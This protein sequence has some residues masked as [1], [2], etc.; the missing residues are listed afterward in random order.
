MIISQVIAGRRI[1]RPAVFNQELAEEL[2]SLH[3]EKDGYELVTARTMCAMDF[4]EGQGR[5]DGAF[6]DLAESEKTEYLNRLHDAGV[7]NIEMEATCF[8]ALTHLAGIRAAI[9]CV[10]FLNRF[11][12]D[13]V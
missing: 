10:A 12:G 2:K 1:Q 8:S 5:L 13:Q 4:Y 7:R 9:V 3:E 11:E 6:C